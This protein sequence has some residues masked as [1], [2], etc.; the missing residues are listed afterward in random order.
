MAKKIINMTADDIRKKGNLDAVIL[1]AKKSKSVPVPAGGRRIATGFAEF[2]EYINRKG[3]PKVEDKKVRISIRLPESVVINLREIDGYTSILSDFIMNG[4]SN[5][6]IK[7][8]AG[9]VS[10]RI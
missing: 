2:K 8:M 9:F 7:N 1:R 5:G 3:R 6:E 4:I 10:K